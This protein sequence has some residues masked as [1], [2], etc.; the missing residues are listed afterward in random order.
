MC[1]SYWHCR[2][3]TTWPFNF[4]HGN[5]FSQFQASSSQEDFYLQGCVFCVFVLLCL[6]DSNMGFLKGLSSDLFPQ[7]LMTQ[8]DFK[9]AWLEFRSL[10]PETTG[11]V[12]FYHTDSNQNFK[13]ENGR[14]AVFLSS[15]LL[16]RSEAP[17]SW[18]LT[19]LP[20]MFKRRCSN[21]AGFWKQLN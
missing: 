2:H 9:D 13:A 12:A 6:I 11:F 1:S 8:N 4:L 14:A 3:L 20:V 16:W 5:L 7:E 18:G 21:N 17:G 19:P 10:W 15:V